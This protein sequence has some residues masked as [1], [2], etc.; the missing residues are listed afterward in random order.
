MGNLLKPAKNNQAYAKVGIFGFQGSG[1]TYTATL[2]A[3]GILQMIEKKFGKKMKCAFFDTETGSDFIV[4]M[5]EEAGYELVAVKSRAF[6]DLKYVFQEAVDEGCAVIIVDSIS[7]VWKDL[8]ESYMIKTGKKVLV[9]SD[10]NNIKPEWGEYTDIF[11]NADLHAVICGRAGYDYAWERNDKGKLELI[12]TGTKMKAEGEFGF[13]PSLVI[14][15]VREP[16]ERADAKVSG[17]AGATQ[18]NVAYVLK[19]RSNTINA[20]RFVNPEYKDFDPHWGSLN[21]GGEH[22]G[23]NTE[24]NSERMFDKPGESFYKRKIKREELLEEIKNIFT[25]YEIGKTDKAKAIKLKMLEGCFGTGNDVTIRETL[26]FDKL[27]QGV[28]LLRHVMKKVV[29]VYAAKGDGGVVD[30]EAL[31]ET[32]KGEMLQKDIEEKVANSEEKAKTEEND[33]IPF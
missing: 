24:S 23:V 5:F 19:D 17:K 16:K 27:E 26:T 12:K 13:E 28:A 33:D 4:K 31:I 14:E 20:R 7:H 11:Q 32:S 8:M 3:I 9:F 15:M 30:Y 1:K 6:I 10:W 22:E 29:S 25:I 2:I 21:L 18:D